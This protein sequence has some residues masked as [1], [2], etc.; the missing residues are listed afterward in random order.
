LLK[1]ILDNKEF[2]L[3]KLLQPIPYVN[4]NSSVYSVLEILKNSKHL[5]AVV[6]DEYGSP[7]GLIT[8]KEI[9]S[10]LVGGFDAESNN[11]SKIFR[12]REDGSFILEGRYQLDDF[13]SR[14][15]IGLSEEE[16]EDMGN[17]TT[18][19]GLIF[20]LLDHIPTEGEFVIYKGYR[21]EVIDMDGNR[22]DKIALEK[23]PEANENQSK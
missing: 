8:T 6:I 23:L 2:D 12:Q 11:K 1:A 17:I 5:Q 18:L 15:E 13:F 9:M 10:A 21:L 3:S 22:I 20:L 14:F 4:E 16:E 7:Q 19:G